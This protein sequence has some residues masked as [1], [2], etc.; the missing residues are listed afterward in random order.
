M[1]DCPQFFDPARGDASPSSSSGKRRH[2]DDIPVT[3][4]PEAC[5]VAVHRRVLALVSRQRDD[6]ATQ[7]R[8]TPPRPRPDAQ[9]VL[10][11]RPWIIPGGL[12]PDAEGTDEESADEE[13]A[14]EERA[15]ERMTKA[16]TK[17]L[18]KA[19]T[20]RTMKAQ[21]RMKKAGTK[22]M[23]KGFM[24]S[25]IEGETTRTMK[26]NNH[27]QEVGGDWDECED[28][29]SCEFPSFSNQDESD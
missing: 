14:D 25:G 12:D 3:P 19:Q 26:R 5:P 17:R 13:S 15:T 7:G 27:G 6:D 24:T 9:G 4:A 11:R 22:R 29:H 10:E 21:K 1:F 20:K 16:R 2:E 8:G 18:A 23:E 28:C